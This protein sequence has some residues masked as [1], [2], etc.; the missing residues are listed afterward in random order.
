MKKVLMG[1]ALAAGM[2]GAVFASPIP[3]TGISST[4]SATSASTAGIF[5]T[6]VDDYINVIEWKNVQPKNFFG[7]VGVGNNE[8]DLGGAHTFGGKTYW[9]SNFAGSFGNYSTTKVS[10]DAGSGTVSP[11]YNSDR[12]QKRANGETNFHFD[13]LIGIG[14][15]GIMPGFKYYDNASSQDDTADPKTKTENQ[16]WQISVAVGTSFENEGK[17]FSPYG[18]VWYGYNYNELADSKPYNF[19]SKVKDGLNTTCSELGLLAGIKI[20][21]PQEAVKHTFDLSA[22]F[23]GRFPA[24]DS[25]IKNTKGVVLSTKPYYTITYEPEEDKFGV[26]ASFGLPAVVDFGK[27]SYIYYVLQPELKTGAYYWVNKHLKLNAGIDFALVG[28]TY[29]HTDAKTDTF[30]WDGNDGSV[31]LTSG[32]TVAFN[33][34]VHLDFTWNIL[35]AIFGND[36]ESTFDQ[37]SSSDAFWGNMNK[38]FTNMAVMID[39]KL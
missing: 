26:G 31:T 5:G 36:F 8:Y 10:G 30:E 4:E 6:D 32:F 11:G 1:F 14:N 20:E 35:N 16:G 25:T 23:D 13:N 12:T 39:V 21:I 9:G 29:E 33:E 19:G 2:M 37:T 38:I 15:F 22:L 7:F 24:S 27:D 18:K 17:K 28:F 3:Q 34:K